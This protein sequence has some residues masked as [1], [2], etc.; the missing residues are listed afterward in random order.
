MSVLLCDGFEKAR[1]RIPPSIHPGRTYRRF[2]FLKKSENLLAECH[3][4][5]LD[6]KKGYVPFLPLKFSKHFPGNFLHRY[7]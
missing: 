1:D 6:K 3:Q 5:L 4:I 2:T 7:D